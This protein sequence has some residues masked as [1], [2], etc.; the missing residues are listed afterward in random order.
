MS[1]TALLTICRRWY[2]SSFRA[3][4][5]VLARSGLA[6]PTR[7]LSGCEQEHGHQAG[8]TDR[9]R[10][11]I[12]R[13]SEYEKI[14]ADDTTIRAVNRDDR[15]HDQGHE[16]LAPG[17][18]LGLR[19][20]PPNVP[21][22]ADEGAP[23]PRPPNRETTALPTFQDITALSGLAALVVKVRV[24]RTGEIRWH[25]VQDDPGTVELRAGLPT[26]PV[27]ERHILVHDADRRRRVGSAVRLRPLVAQTAHPR[28]P[29][30]TPPV[31]VSDPNSFEDGALGPLE[32]DAERG[33][34]RGE[35]EPRNAL[36]Y[37][38]VNDLQD[39]HIGHGVRHRVSPPSPSGRSLPSVCIL[40][41]RLTSLP[42]ALHRD[43]CAAVGGP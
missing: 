35:Q 42:R 27:G 43:A 10:K 5:W 17:Y 40:A 23:P 14:P 25:G 7:R 36:R 6:T 33:M 13:A 21:H 38:C 37:I 30:G 4:S 34:E 12:E 41:G 28:C 8:V 18:P 31:A 19:S 22:W 20:Q 39:I 1:R 2:P 24:L 9:A 32:S 29:W 26:L 3:G 16:K 15:A 11:D